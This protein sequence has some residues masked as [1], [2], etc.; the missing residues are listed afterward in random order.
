MKL[1][2]NLQELLGSVDVPAD[3]V[4]L[5]E[6]YEVHT[7]RM[8]RDGVPVENGKYVTHGVMVE[9]LVNGQFGYYGTPNLSN[10]GVSDAANKAYQQAMIA[11]NHSVY[12]FDKKARPAYKGNYYSPYVKD[13]D[14]LSAGSLNQLLLDAYQ[15]LKVSDKIVSASSLCQT[16][17]TVS[18]SVT[19]VQEVLGDMMGDAPACPD[20]GHITI[21]NGSCYKCLNCGN[22]LGCS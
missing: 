13:K 8:I 15:S 2:V 11:S 12:T 20:C 4:G 17:E 7:P 21:R 22:S 5:R 14:S 19:T 16:I 6:Y 18:N 9:V 1:D 3:W 10:H